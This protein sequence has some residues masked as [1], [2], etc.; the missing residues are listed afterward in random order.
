MSTRISMRSIGITKMPSLWVGRRSS[1]LNV[2]SPLV[3]LPNTA[4]WP[5]RWGASP[6]RIEKEEEALSGSEYL[7]L[8]EFL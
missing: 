6:R 1:F 5:S 2:S 3:T 4:Y 7:P 8:R